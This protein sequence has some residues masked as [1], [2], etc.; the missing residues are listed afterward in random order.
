MLN[1]QESATLS[2]ETEEVEKDT[3][4]ESESALNKAKHYNDRYRKQLES[5]IELD[6]K[7]LLSGASMI[8]NLETSY[9]S[10]SHRSQCHDEQSSSALTELIYSLSITMQYKEKSQECSQESL[11]ETELKDPLC[12]KQYEELMQ[13]IQL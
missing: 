12:K 6:K 8:P 11:K 7:I 9:S 4:K 10:Y 13:K 1:T 2:Q 5:H 3:K